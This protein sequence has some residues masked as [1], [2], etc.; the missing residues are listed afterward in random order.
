MIRIP[1]EG[2]WT[3]DNSGD[4]RG[5]LQE[6]FNIDL[7]SNKG[8]VRLL[9]S[10]RI[11][12]DGSP[13]GFGEVA[14][15]ERFIQKLYIASEHASAHDIWIGN[16]SPFDTPV[17]DSSS[18]EIVPS[19]T[20]LMAWNNGLYLSTGNELFYS[21]DGTAWN[22][23]GS[24]V[25]TSGD[26]HLLTALN[27]VLYVT[28]QDYKV[29]SVTSGN[30][31]QNSGAQT[32]NLNLPGWG[33][34]VLMTGIDKIWVG[35]S[36]NNG[37]MLSYVF[38]W[39]GQTANT[40]D[41]RYEI[42]AS[43]I[44][45]GV[46][47]DGVPYI[48]DSRGRLMVL[49]GG[50]F[51]EL[52]RFP[53]NGR[54]FKGFNLI[55]NDDRAIHP[56][57]MAIDGDEILINVANRTDEIS[58]EKA[59]EFPSGVWGWSQSNGLY[60]KIAPSYQAVADTGTTGLTDYGQYRCYSGGPI[61]VFESVNQG[62]DPDTP[63][64]GRIVFAMEYFT[65]ADD[66]ST[67]TQWG[68]FTD[69]TN[70]NTQKAGWVTTARIDSSYFRDNW[71]TIYTAL[72]ELSTTGDLVEIKYR[73]KDETPTYFSGTWTGT[74]RFNTTTELS[75]YAQGNEITIVQGKGGG[76]VAH[77]S[78]LTYGAGSEVV[79]DRDITGITVGQTSK[80]RIEKWTKIDKITDLSTEGRT[81]GV[82]DHWIQI[83]V[84]LQ[85]TGR[86]ELYGML[87]KNS[88]SLS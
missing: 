16:N 72:S 74:D 81:I 79:L 65:D 82:Q 25:L 87:I 46:V 39:D 34:T 54:T 38:E 21:T 75:D 30:T 18:V 26:I 70:D 83:K 67:D 86:Q 9:R 63:N 59:N 15:F 40:P 66:A 12:Y 35:L 51:Q 20:D 68:L 1:S 88:S 17:N 5:T 48:V 6:T 55:K 43:G 24:N 7:E 61:M 36:N 69:D 32:L 13:T 22:E 53:M 52:A 73:T 62:N 11:A 85:W 8:R 78:S 42:D 77:A 3:Q 14:A 47:K 50:A 58:T 41:A 71:Q 19:T 84:Y 28:D 10:K 49:N 23:I 29:F 76:A 57:G 80:F 45:A 64:G 33:T 56:R 60:H 37:G 27:D 2:V 44:M 4:T 31:F